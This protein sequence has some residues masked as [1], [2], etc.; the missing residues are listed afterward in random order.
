MRRRLIPLIWLACLATVLLVGGRSPFVRAVSP[1]VATAEPAL[2]QTETGLVRGTVA[3]GV[4]SFK[5]IP[6]AAPPV[7]S[8]RWRAPQPAIAWAGVRSASDYGHDCMQLPIPGDS[9]ASGSTLSEDCLGLNLWRPAQIE[10]ERPLPVMVW[11]H[12]GGFLNG[13]ASAAIFDGTAFAQK[14][15]VLVS[16][17]YRLGRLG[18]FAHPA[19]TRAAEGPLGNYGLMDQVAALQWVQRNIAAFGGD[20][21]RVTLIGESAGGISV[22][23]HL[24]SPA[25]RGLF[26]Q[27]VVLSGGGRTFLVG[28]R[29]LQTGT[30]ALPSAEQSGLE[31][32]RSQGITSLGAKALTMLRGL[33]AEQVNGDLSMAA[34]LEK[35]PTY[36]GGPVFDGEVITALPEQALRQGE[37]A[38]VPLIIG[39]TTADLPVTFPP[40]DNPLSFFGADAEQAL[41]AY[42]PEGNLPPEAV[43]TQIAVDITMHEPARFVAR[44]MRDRGNPVWLYRFGYVAESLRPETL[45]AP[46][47][48]ELPFM[49][50]TLDA[51]YGKAVTAKDRLAA[52]QFHHYI[53]NFVITGNP[54]HAGLPPWAE[55]NASSAELLLLTPEAESVMAADPWAQRLDLVERAVETSS[56]PPR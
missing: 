17:N 32:A 11:V 51:R 25:A 47:A 40:L 53:A 4:V 5:G 35:P 36:A 33:P 43:I 24:T 18:F 52:Q 1:A 22:M 14:G 8:L 30:L 46:H 31:F 9:A 38:D 12:G 19:L 3:D 42:N 13:G 27:A 34:L 26:H 29:R 50:D 44:R 16:F 55:Y 37:V 23:H 49:F 48:S 21:N 54:N 28:L 10:A 41:A 2:V 45:G 7:G 15:M 56:G 6:Y 20:P 39:T